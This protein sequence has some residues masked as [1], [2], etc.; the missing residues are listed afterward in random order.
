M[1][2]AIEAPKDT[3][4]RRALVFDQRF[5]DT[6]ALIGT[7]SEGL[8]GHHLLNDVARSIQVSTRAS[9]ALERY[10]LNLWQAIRYPA[11]AG[12]KLEE[13]DT[14]RLVLAGAS[15]RGLS[16]LMRAVRVAAWLNGRDA[17]LPEDV[18]EV[19]Y[20]TMA[21][22]VFFEPIYELRREAIA[23]ALINELFRVVAVP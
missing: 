10:V 20:E 22:R 18:R 5:H 4:S 8:L 3:A 21:H 16:Y 12:V 23:P 13:A 6:D 17:A 7:I 14:E 1:E 2:I 15:P 19:F 9:D 11:E